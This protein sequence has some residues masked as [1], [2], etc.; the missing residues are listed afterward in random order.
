MKAPRCALRNN[1]VSESTEL[2]VESLAVD[3]ERWRALRGRSST[4]VHCAT[5]VLTGLGVPGREEC[6]GIGGST[7]SSPRTIT[8]SR[9]GSGAEI[10][11]GVMPYASGE[12]K[13]MC[14]RGSN[15]GRLAVFGMRWRVHKTRITFTSPVRRT[16]ECRTARDAPYANDGKGGSPWRLKMKSARTVAQKGTSWPPKETKRAIV[17]GRRHTVY[18]T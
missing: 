6:S 15:M 10:T 4:D 11:N 16:D 1:G 8:S 17:T 13:L 9:R 14:L 18:A 7:F 3:S 2:M 5:A 12:S